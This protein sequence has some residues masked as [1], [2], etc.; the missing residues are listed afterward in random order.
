M[1]S[2]SISLIPLE[3]RFGTPKSEFS[4]V[5]N[6]QIYIFTSKFKFF[7]YTN[8]DLVLGQRGLALSSTSGGAAGSSKRPQRPQSAQMT[9]ASRNHSPSKHSLAKNNRPATANP[10]RGHKTKELRLDSSGEYSSNMHSRNNHPHGQHNYHPHAV[11]G[12]ELSSEDDGHWS[13]VAASNQFG[14]GGGFQSVPEQAPMT[15]P[16]RP[17][18][19][20]PFGWKVHYVGGNDGTGVPVGT[21]YY[22]NQY[23][24]ESRWLHPSQGNTKGS[25]PSAMPPTNVINMQESINRPFS[26]ASEKYANQLAI[27]VSPAAY[28]TSGSGI[29]AMDNTY[30][31]SYGTRVLKQNPKS[32]ERQPL[33]LDLSRVDDLERGVKNENSDIQEGVYLA[34]REPPS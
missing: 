23:T 29:D 24:N 16:W 22:H 31:Q 12:S 17:E 11:Q 9:N 27:Q 21:P 14:Y 7:F 18:N 34:P 15:Q 1:F 25:S 6:P 4:D 2:K 26:Y 8:L 13:P 30:G 32:K 3:F 5:E 10:S 33:T 28:H 20:L 19:D